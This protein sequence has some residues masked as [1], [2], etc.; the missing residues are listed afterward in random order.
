MALPAIHRLMFSPKPEIGQVVVELV[1][2]DISKG[3]FAMAVRTTGPEL[4]VVDILVTGG[5]IIGADPQAVLKDLRGRSVHIMAFGTINALVR[6]FERKTGLVVIETADLVQRGKRFFRV[7]LLAIRSEVTLM[8]IRMTTVAIGKRHSGKGLE[9]F[10]TSDLFPVAFNAF[11]ILMLAAESKVR[12]VMV[13]FGSR[14]EGIGHM[15]AR[16]IVR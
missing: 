8:D 14:S 2:I 15:A 3:F 9:W 13:K 6:S 7:T 11:Y 12:L 4:A 16:T 5:T 1:G 10:S